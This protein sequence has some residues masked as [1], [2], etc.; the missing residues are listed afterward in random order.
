ML[1]FDFCKDKYCSA[2]VPGPEYHE[3]K[4]GI[5]DIRAFVKAGKMMKK[6]I[7]RRKRR[8]YINIILLMCV[9]IAV[10][11]G[12]L[13][14]RI[15]PDSLNDIKSY[16]ISEYNK[17]FDFTDSYTDMKKLAGIAVLVDEPED[18]AVNTGEE[19]DFPELFYPYRA[20]LSDKGKRVYNQVY[21]NAELYNDSFSLTDFV[22]AD[23]FE[24]VMYAVYNDHPELFWLE[25]TYSY[26]YTNSGE[27]VSA[28]LVFNISR[29]EL[30]AAKEKFNNSALAVI[31]ETEFIDSDIEKERYVHDYIIN[32]VVY[33]EKSELNQSA[34]SALVNGRSVCAGY[35][36]A[37]QY[38]MI[39]IG[40]PCYYC[41]GFANQGDHAWNLV[42]IN[43]K[44]ANVDVSWD[45]CDNDKVTDERR[46]KYF[47]ISDEEIGQTHVRTG[48]SLEIK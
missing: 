37:F 48:L 32:N 28:N 30:E 19:Y 12:I 5:W 25:T 36:R 47:N 4:C 26:G 17:R 23:E 6:S 16:V 24:R 38:I 33:D 42:M 3:I 2:F 18:E 41:T 7:K 13:T 39:Q 21:K 31:S 20:L 15:S 11:I 35:S 22:S 43:G 29:E 27:V 46:Y 34:Y 8:L 1:L 45:D 40:I 44:L 10:L 9:I 14:E